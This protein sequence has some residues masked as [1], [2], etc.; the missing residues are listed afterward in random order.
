MNYGVLGVECPYIVFF[1]NIALRVLFHL[2][3]H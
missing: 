3:N 2:E 1:T